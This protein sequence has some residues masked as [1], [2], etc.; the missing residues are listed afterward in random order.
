MRN[1]VGI[2]CRLSDEDRFKKD[3]NDDSES[4]A[5]QKSMLLKYALNKNW[6]VVNVYSDDDYS[7][8]DINRP[9]FNELIKDCEDGKIDIVLCKTQSRF[10][11]DMEIIEKY[12]HNKF[13]EWNVRFIS[14]VDNADTSIESNK[15]SRQ[16][17]GLINEWYLE[18]LSQNIKRSL[19]NKREDG[20][21][22]GSFAPYG[23]MKSSEN[24]YKLVIDLVASKVVKDIFKMYENGYGYSDKQGCYMHVADFKRI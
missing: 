23:Y 21:F 18:D 16:I 11:R 10:S 6:E 8:A 17:N 12:L 14:I 22:V 5:N 19:K 1:R 2:Y 15:K 20:L 24:K 7:G 9:K 13:I 3:K 4:I